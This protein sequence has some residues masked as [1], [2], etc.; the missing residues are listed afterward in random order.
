LS[1]WL[2]LS[3]VSGRSTSGCEAGWTLYKIE[4][5]NFVE[6]YTKREDFG[7]SSGKLLNWVLQLERQVREL[8][9]GRQ[10]SHCENCA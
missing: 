9:E 4:V 6:W 3:K 7:L 1:T 2:G 8:V 10:S 5:D